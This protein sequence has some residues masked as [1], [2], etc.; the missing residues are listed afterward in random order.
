[1]TVVSIPFECAAEADVLDDQ[2]LH[3]GVARPFA[4]AEQRRIGGAAAV[5]PGGGRVDHGLVKI[6]M[7]MPLQKMA[8]DS[9]ILDEGP[10]ELVHATGAGR[11]RD[12]SR[13]IPSYRR[14]G[15]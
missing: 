1:M 4:Q 14:A 5:Q 3:G 10:D 15:S 9:R 13:R 12:R 8:G 7:A 11:R 6:V 2:P